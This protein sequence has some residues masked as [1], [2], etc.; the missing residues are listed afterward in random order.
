LTPM[1]AEEY[2]TF[3]QRI[4]DYMRKAAKEAKV[5]TS[6]VNPNHA[7]DDALQEFVGAVLD[8]F[9]FRDD[10]QVLWSRVARYGMYNSLAQTLLKLT[11]PGVPD[12]YQ[13]TELWDF[14]LV[15]PD[16]RRPV[17]YA[18][19]R[20]LLSALQER[21]RLVGPDL[22][23]FARELLDTWKDGRVKLY[24]THQTLVYRREH[25]ALFQ[26]GAYIPVEVAGLKQ[27]HVCAFARQ[28]EQHVIVVVVPR[29]LTRILLDPDVLSLEPQV[30]GDTWLA[31]PEACAGPRYRNVFTG[32]CVSAVKGDG[33]SV[34]SLGE[35]F[36]NFPVALLERI[37]A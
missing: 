3:K 8:D 15:D 7:Y 11:V 25:P 22:V 34:L 33:K 27:Q 20:H 31:L 23:A 21:L 29:F 6:W 35:A 18:Q 9:L 5:N 30:W 28:H 32:E 37:G 12:L 24:I 14:S 13:G 17:D 10:F 16:N 4:Q 36:A 26:L 2:A 19:R 1:T